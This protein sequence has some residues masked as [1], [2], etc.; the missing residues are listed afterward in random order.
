MITANQ[1]AK[2]IGCTAHHVRF[3]VRTD[4]LRA[5]KRQRPGPMGRVVYRYWVNEEDA[6]K[7]RDKMFV[8]GRPRKRGGKST[9]K[10]A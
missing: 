9:K 4:K 6:R 3:L 1:A 10:T 2:V 5:E 7:Y 8:R